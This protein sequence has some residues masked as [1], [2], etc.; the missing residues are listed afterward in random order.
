M[1][2]RQPANKNNIARFALFPLVMTVAAVLSIALPTVAGSYGLALCLG[3][4]TGAGLFLSGAVVGGR[5][6]NARKVGQSRA[7]VPMR[8]GA[9][10]AL[11]GIAA[12]AQGHDPPWAWP[13][14]V[15]IGLGQL[16]VSL[17]AVGLAGHWV[18][19]TRPAKET[20]AAD[21]SAAKP[22]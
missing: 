20:E 2:A 21:D 6:G 5:L 17:L 8:M 13:E 10:L 3:V 18:A 12:G 11:A 15:A 16:I 22:L 9:C 4:S 14:R 7:D 19:Q 1:P